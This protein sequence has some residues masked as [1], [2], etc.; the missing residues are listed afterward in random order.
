H[1]LGSSRPPVYMLVRSAESG[2]PVD[3][4]A[5]VQE[6]RTHLATPGRMLT[7][8][9]CALAHPGIIEIASRTGHDFVIIDAE[10]S[11]IDSLDQENLI[12]AADA[13]GLVSLVKLK[14]IDEVEIRNALD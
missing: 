2:G 9:S 14:E 12:R 6:F 10:H 13:H 7:G 5:A 1:A 4:L 8:M 11:A 3:R